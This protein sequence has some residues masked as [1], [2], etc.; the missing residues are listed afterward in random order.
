MSCWIFLWNSNLESYLLA[1]FWRTVT[2]VEL[3]AIVMRKG[4]Y[5]AFE[6]TGGQA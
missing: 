6:G 1:E 4:H 3:A 2:N 5:L